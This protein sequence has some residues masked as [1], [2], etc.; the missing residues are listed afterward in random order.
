M[1]SLFCSLCVFCV[2]VMLL[3][4][5]R[6]WHS[7]QHPKSVS[8]N[9]YLNAFHMSD[10]K[11]LQTKSKFCFILV[12]RIR[13]ISTPKFYRRGHQTA[14]KVLIN[15]QCHLLGSVWHRNPEV[16]Q[17]RFQLTHC[18]FLMRGLCLSVLFVCAD[19]QYCLEPRLTALVP[20]ICLLSLS[21]VSSEM[22]M[23]QPSLEAC[24]TLA[25]VLKL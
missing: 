13:A 4:L 11:P 19:F 3:K 24:C 14:E 12:K 9:R 20:D 25:T 17:L 22:A 23:E 2:A 21:G 15:A 18:E 1:A 10:T 7:D 5:M 16:Q 8:L 6:R